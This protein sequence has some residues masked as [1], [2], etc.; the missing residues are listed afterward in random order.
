M[1]TS[2]MI[3]DVKIQL[4]VHF[5]QGHNSPTRRFLATAALAFTHAAADKISRSISSSGTFF[6]LL[7]IRNL[8]P[9]QSWKR[10][11]MIFLGNFALQV[12]CC[13]SGIDRLT[14]A[15]RFLHRSVLFCDW[16]RNLQWE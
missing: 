7:E 5:M 8:D 16:L 9:K 15:K 2:S 14:P 12:T 13:Q 3:Y 10:H 4:A 11:T 1:K 6:L